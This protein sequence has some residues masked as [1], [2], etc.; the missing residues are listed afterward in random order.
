MKVLSVFGTR[1][2]AIKMAP[3]IRQLE[4][5]RGSV[6]SIVCVT[7]QHRQ[8][9]DQVLSLFE[10]KPQFDL[11]LMRENQTLAETTARILTALDEVITEVEPDWVLTQG[12]T[13]TAMVGTLA[14]F[15]R[16]VRAG[17]VE[18][19]LR[20]WDKRHPF[21][22]E[23]NRKIADS[24][25][26]L[27]FAPTETA[28][29]NLLQEGIADASI[30]VTGNTVIDALLDVASRP[31][32]WST[33]P[34]SR[35]PQDRRLILVTAHRRESFGEPF[36][37][38][39]QALAAIARR[40]DVEIV[41]PVHLNPNVKGVVHELLENCA[42]ITLIEPLD[43][44]PLVHLLKRS[45]LV[46][47]D[48]GGLQEEAPGLGK[49]VLVMRETTERPEGIAAGT[50]RLVGT[51]PT[52]IVAEVARLLDDPVAYDEMARAINP[53]GDGKASAR[54]VQHILES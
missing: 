5:H 15:Y 22:E 29:N 35:I 24:V 54:I 31:F 26:D 37:R 33:G 39:C 43:Y 13:T 25:C 32:E 53:Y 23:I 1:P 51:D 30:K 52:K 7:A 40:G 46:L 9:L 45:D 3:V 27:H 41:Y 36:Q 11:D 8:M 50:V 28:R 47:T 49:P 20:T 14:A 16:G 6:E 34:L 44:L 4:L 19:G 17:H 38:I 21:P 2:E 10:L 18:A 12:D 48:S 42:N